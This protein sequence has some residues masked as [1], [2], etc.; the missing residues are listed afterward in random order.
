MTTTVAYIANADSHDISVLQLDVASGAVVPL[1]KL[2]VDGVVMPL[3]KSPDRRFLYASIRSEPVAVQSFAIDAASGRL[4]PIGK[5]PLPASMCWISTDRSGRFLLSASYGGSQIA[6]SPIDGA[7]IAGA[8]QQSAATEKNAHSVQATPDNRFLLASCLGGGVVLACRFDSSSGRFEAP[9]P[10][11]RARPG[12]GPRHFVFH[13]TRPL[14]YLLNELD[15]T[16]DI[17]RFDAEAGRLETL[18]H[19]AILPA[20]FSGEPWAADLHLT[21]DGRFLYA[22]ERRASVLAGFAVDA[23]T[24]G[25]APLGRVPTETQPRGFAIDPSGHWLLAVGQLSNR[26]SVYAIDNGTGALVKQGEHPVG[27]NPNWIEIVTLD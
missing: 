23:A 21:P 6:V 14:V 1:Q 2:A 16:I 22:C 8:A 19:V 27:Q 7:G 13:P 18:G 10:A 4:A 25:L 20:D 15:A 3:A 5:S 9:V 12:A 11:W 24:G 26:L 17:L